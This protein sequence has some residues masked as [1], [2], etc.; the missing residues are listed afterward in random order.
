LAPVCGERVAGTGG[1]TDDFVLGISCAFAGHAWQSN[2]A[3]KTP[4]T[5]QRHFI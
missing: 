1:V 4:L 3:S 5:C 2:I